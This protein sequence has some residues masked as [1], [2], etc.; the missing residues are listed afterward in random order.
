[1]TDNKGRATSRMPASSQRDD[2]PERPSL[3]KS[4]DRATQAS[5][6][7]L[8]SMYSPDDSI[9]S[10]PSSLQ[11][12]QSQGAKV[13]IPRLRRHTDDPLAPPSS[14]SSENKHRVS[15]ACEPCRQRKTKCSGE[16]PVCKHC[17]DFRITCIYA[18]S[19]R[20]RTKRYVSDRVIP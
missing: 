9:P 19:K 4:S 12:P 17:E 20:D 18:D 5:R 10:T 1:M 3:S 6:R 8:P 16:R 15:H 13:A 11:A 7:S 2:K 14:N